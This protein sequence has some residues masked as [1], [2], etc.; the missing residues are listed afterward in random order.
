MLFGQ[1][2]KLS[3]KEKQAESFHYTANSLSDLIER[4]EGSVF[5]FTSTLF[6]QTLKTSVCRKLL[7]ET[8]TS[9]GKKVL[10]LTIDL[11]KEKT[12][13]QKDDSKKCFDEEVLLGEACNEFKSILEERKSK[14][15]LVFLNLP[16]VNIFAA[17][18]ES[19]KLCDGVILIERYSYTKYCNYEQSL[20]YL[21]ENHIPIIGVIPYK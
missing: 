4:S 11:K 19:A 9:P 13:P 6:N 21:K 18:L 17:A 10:L 15:D 14:Y 2:Y 20:L 8:S 12:F 1:S 7:E 5:A 3:K 16:P